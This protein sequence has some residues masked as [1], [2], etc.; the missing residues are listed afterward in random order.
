MPIT[1]EIIINAYDEL[2]E[3]FHH[4]ARYHKYLTGDH[5]LCYASENYENV[6]GAILRTLVD[7]RLPAIVSCVS[8]KMQIEDIVVD[9]DK[10]DAV[11]AWVHGTLL[12]R[13]IASACHRAL[14]YGDSYVILA[15]TASGFIKPYLQPPGSI[16][17][18]TADETGEPAGAIK[19][20]PHSDGRWRLTIWD[21]T[22][23]TRYAAAHKSCLPDST[24]DDYYL[25]EQISIP[26][27]RIPV[28]AFV[29]SP[30]EMSERGQS[31]LHTVLPMQDMLNKAWSDM[32]VSMEF[33][34]YPQRWVTGV[35]P[36][37]DE[38]GNEIPYIVPGMERL[39]TSSSP[40]SHFGSFAVADLSQYT[41]VIDK[42]LQAMAS[43]ARVPIHAFAPSGNWPSG[44]AM[45]KAE[46]QLI[47]T[48]KDRMEDW[49]NITEELVSTYFEWMGTP[50]SESKCI[51]KSIDIKDEKADAETE[52]LRVD[53]ILAKVELGL[54]KEQGLR[55]SGYTDDQISDFADENAQDNA[56]RAA[57][58]ASLAGAV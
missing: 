47:A 50:T 26:L 22:G 28:F 52:K 27:S 9:E 23:I 55:E 53:T 15:R 8:D 42:T 33:C 54:S 2:K 14:A 18:W 57:I 58:A 20:W 16:Y 29:N 32:A 37:T 35:D 7:N 31:I 40:D 34:A 38:N 39:M 17:M 13:T 12:K 1:S 5:P 10:Q 11:N 48:A 4:Y 49:G 51:W 44:E 3:R 43:G 6:F 46:D 36:R 24:L 41:S 25:E 19:S 21:N 56:G 30:D 45:R